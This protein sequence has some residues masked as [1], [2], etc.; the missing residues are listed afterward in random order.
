MGI[1]IA[2]FNCDNK[3]WQLQSSQLKGKIPKKTAFPS[4]TIHKFRSPQATLTSDQL[5]ANSKFPITLSGW[6]IH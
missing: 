4:D 3:C 2:D 5:A 1:R 6:I